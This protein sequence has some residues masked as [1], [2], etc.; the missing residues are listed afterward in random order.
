M[1]RTIPSGKKRKNRVAASPE[2][3]GVMLAAR[4]IPCLDVDDGRV[5]KGVKFSGLKDA[6]DPVE[7]ARVY[8]D[9]GADELTFLDVGASYKS[10]SILIDIVEKVSQ[11][12]FIPLTVGGGLRDLND[13]RNVLNAG[14]DKIAICTRAIEEPELIRQAAHTFGSQCIVVSIDARRNQNSWHAFTHGGGKVFGF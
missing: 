13:M 11:A 3:G 10:R 12:I 8:N 7:L 9:Q 6:G 2:L 4:I 5:V 14:A 1:R